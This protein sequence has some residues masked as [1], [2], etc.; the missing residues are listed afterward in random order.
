MSPGQ[1]CSLSVQKSGL[2]SV[3]HCL[4]LSLGSYIGGQSGAN[5]LS[6]LLMLRRL[7]RCSSAGP[8]TESLD[9]HILQLGYQ[10]LN[11]IS[12]DWT[13]LQQC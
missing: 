11:P 7:H 12:L 3:K 9:I 13:H 1:F 6:L 2:G 4:A 5:S 10:V 8:A